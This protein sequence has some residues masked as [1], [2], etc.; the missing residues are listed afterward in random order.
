MMLRNLKRFYIKLVAALRRLMRIVQWFPLRIYRLLNHFKLGIFGFPSKNRVGLQVWWQDLPFYLVDILCL[1][2]IV[3]TFLDFAKWGTRL[4]SPLEIKMAVSV[5]GT[6]LQ[7][8]EVRI[9]NRAR[10][11]CKKNRIAYVSFFTINAWGPLQATTFIHELVHVWQFQKFGSVYIPKALRAQRSPQ[12]YDY[13]G[14][15]AL[16]I[17]KQKKGKLTDFNFEQQ[18][19]IV[20]DYFAIREGKHP[21]WGKA[22]YT[23]LPIYE[24]FVQQIR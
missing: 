12:G 21:V 24:Y 8:N 6:S 9:D 11:S 13:G 10:I 18:A 14:I 3:E 20:S 15:D 1:P 7:L 19:D 2:E 17:A 4:L 22:V 23:D 16:K 5:F